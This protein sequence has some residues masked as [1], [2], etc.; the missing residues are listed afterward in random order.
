MNEPKAKILDAASSLFLAGGAA[1]LS[2]RAIAKHAGVSTIGIYSHFQGKQGI[3]D[4]LY[5]QGFQLVEQA[6]SG[7]IDNYIDGHIDDFIDDKA[8][9]ANDELNDSIARVML[10]AGNYLELAETHEAHYKLIFGE[11]NGSYSPSKEAKQAS[12]EAFKALTSVTTTLLPPTA[13]TEEQQSAAMQI[14]ALTHGF[15]SLKHHAVSAMIDNT[16]WKNQ[17][18]VAIELQAK[19]IQT[20]SLPDTR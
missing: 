9:S 6:M 5:I 12:I 16:D 14:W 17:A 20:A 3:L 13:S 18:L 4:T 7:G 15:V 11:E 8:I 19:A 10:A 2:V 1:A